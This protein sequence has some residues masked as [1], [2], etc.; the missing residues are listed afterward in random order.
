MFNEFKRKSSF[1]PSKGVPVGALTVN[2]PAAWVL[3]WTAMSVVAPLIVIDVPF[4][5]VTTLG[6]ATILL[7]VIA[8]LTN[9]LLAPALVAVP[10]ETPP[11]LVRR[12]PSVP[13]VLKINGAA[14]SV[15]NTNNKLDAS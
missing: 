4:A 11:P 14:T 10:I 12:I 5:I 8:P 9:R 3:T 7:E 13:F 2:V 15:P 6:G 1:W